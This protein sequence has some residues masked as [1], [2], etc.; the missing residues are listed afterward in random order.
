[1][2]KKPSAL[3]G[4]RIVGERYAQEKRAE[5]PDGRMPLIEHLKELRGRVVKIAI[6]VV[7]GAVVAWY[8]EPRIWNFIQRP[9]CEAIGHC[10]NAFGHKLILTGVTDAF[11]LRL[12]VSII[13]SVVVTS[14]IWLYQIWAFIAPGL[15]AREKRWTWAFIGT[16]VP[17]FA[18]GCYFAYL[19]MGKGLKFFMSMS[20]GNLTNLFEADTYISY[21]IAMLLGFA[22]CF[23]VPLF[24]VILN[25]ARVVTHERFKKWRRMIIFGV[26]VFA[27]IASPSPDPLTMLMLGG[28]VAVLVEVAEVLIYFN[29]KRYLRNHPDPYAGLDDDELSPVDEPADVDHTLN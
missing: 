6:V 22:L 27:G 11:T 26:F 19:A 3:E 24:L 4:A 5:S 29:D 2:V 7:I 10:S 20:G 13:S 18:L 14:P 23:E 8:F 16:A 12:K 28:I 17:L 9:Y 21:W 15:Y 25:L 1:M